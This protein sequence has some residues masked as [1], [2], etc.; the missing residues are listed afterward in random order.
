MSEGI[1]K[2][3]LQDDLCR[4]AAEAE[5]LGESARNNHDDARAD[6]WF[7]ISDRADDLFLAL[8]AEEPKRRPV[9]LVGEGVRV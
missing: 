3:S 8:T 1:P 4:L 7:R 6:Y 2:G 9:V 5:E